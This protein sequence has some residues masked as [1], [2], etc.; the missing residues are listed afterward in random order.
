MSEC[1][2]SL[3]SYDPTPD[4]RGARYGVAVARAVAFG[5]CVGALALSVPGA[6]Q[7][8]LPPQQ[9]PDAPSS[10]GEP[11]TAAP[12]APASFRPGFLNA[13]GRLF[14]DSKSTVDSQIKSTQETLGTFGS[15]ARDAAGAVTAVP[16][17]RIVTGRQ[18]C[19]AA[20]NG[21]PDCHQ[22]VEA[23]CR[24]KGFQS[25]RSLEVSSSQRCPARV[26]IAGRQ[27][28]E[29]ECRMETYVTRALC[30]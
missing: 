14:G 23:L 17:T 13:L 9:V 11:P 30:Q 21:A 8:P 1:R 24:S 25:G 28:K 22:G 27:P 29:G 26:W 10:E 4:R 19:P 5:L 3:S 6:A 16:G 20:A 15:Q 18:L 12:D 7:Q 2:S